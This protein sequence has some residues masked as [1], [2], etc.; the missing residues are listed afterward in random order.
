VRAALEKGAAGALVHTLPADVAD[1]APLLAVPDTLE[2][3]R[4][5][6]AFAR[7]RLA[8]QLVA[9]TGSVGK[10]T[11]KEMLRAILA[12]HGR[13]WAAEASHNNHWG[14]PL[15]LARTPREAAFC[16]AEIGMNHAGEI[17]PLTRLAAPHVALVTSVEKVHV[18][19]L[20]SIEAVAD[21]KLSIQDGLTSGILVLPRDSA[22]YPRLRAGARHPVRTFGRH[23]EADDRLLAARA[24]EAGTLVEAE[25]AGTRI[26][27]RLA[28]PG[29]HM[30]MNALAALSAA[31]ALG[32]DPARG[33]AALEGFAPVAG[34]GARRRI[35]V[36]GGT[37]LLLDESYN[38]S[39]VA[40]RAAFAVLARR[41][42]ILGD[43][44]ELGEF[45]PAE[46]AA[47]ADAAASADIVHTCGPLMQH[48]RDVLPEARRGL[49][50]ADSAALAPHLAATLRHGDAVL[51]KGSLGSRMK[52]VIDAI[53]QPAPPP[54][55]DS[56]TGEA[57]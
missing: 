24:D 12:A 28:A 16:V 36:P 50:A 27:T 34:R 14:L 10:T 38:A 57:A 53:D 31:V 26:T 32:A 56:T 45:G 11:T 46:H 7:A 42:A 9:V 3:L 40:V 1:D 29:E 44:R 55:G 51:V 52:L 8:G 41:V 21:E 33:A 20:S 19:H 30:A 47:L 49:H 39:S 25:I 18:G 23:A 35:A 4:A 54:P 22:M 6:A 2:A 17:T 5:L 43:M 37:A 48:L 15:T 13:T